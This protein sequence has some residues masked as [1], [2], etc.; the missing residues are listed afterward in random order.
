MIKG[1]AK[2]LRYLV[3]FLSTW[4]RVLLRSRKVWLTKLVEIESRLSRFKIQTVTKMISKQ[5][6]SLLIRIP[7]GN[8]SER[9]RGLLVAV[10]ESDK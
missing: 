2:V 5:S 3:V 7:N 4:L 6:K 8:L 9:E 10:I 1:Y